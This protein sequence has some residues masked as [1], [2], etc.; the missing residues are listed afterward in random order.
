MGRPPRAV[1]VDRAGSVRDYWRQRIGQHTQDSY[2]GVPMIKF[3]EDLRVYEHLLW[4]S[5][6]D[7]VIEIGCR[8]GGSA[9]W[10][11][12]RLLTNRSYGRIPRAKVISID[13]DISEARRWLSRADPDYERHISL[14]E[15]DV[16]DPATAELAGALIPPGARCLV[17]EDSEHVAETTRGALEHF[18]RFVP[19]G[20]YLVVEDG[21]VDDDELRS[22]WMPSGVLPALSAWLETEPGSAFAVRKDL[23][24]YGVT[25]HPGGF[26]Q[27]T[28]LAGRA[29]LSPAL[30][31]ELAAPPSWMYGWDLGNGVTAPIPG[32]V[33][34]K[35]HETRE[36][37][38]RPAI[39]DYLARTQRTGRGVDLG[40]NEGYY[41]H[42][43]LDMGMEHAVGV[44]VR[45]VNI[46]RAEL[47][48]EHL[49]VPADRL[50]LHTASV[51][52]VGPQQL[53]TFDVVL[54][55][56]LI[57]HLEDPGG[58]LR[59]ARSLAAPGGL[60]V[61]ETQLTAQ[62][63]PIPHGWGVPDHHEQAAA[64]FA[65][66]WE[67]DEADLLASSGGVLSLIPNAAALEAL[68]KAAGFVDTRWL[69]APPG[70]E[71]Q[72][73]AGDRGIV[74]AVAPVD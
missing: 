65:A 1:A 3:P 40:C 69:S 38:I 51:Y 9:L 13:L 41:S 17:I 46:R 6:S 33:L 14:V 63:D 66:R 64:S 2:A 55:L 56:G 71:A 45:S 8:Y 15:G 27:R 59:V 61:V 39:A 62:H 20:G 26:L 48:R 30:R 25:C 68:M 35:V 73:V 18:A 54:V 32:T 31:D 37:M 60:V 50:E 53:G 52:D 36:R 5:R 58:A 10:F 72:F 42:M 47:V 67:D 12:D 34:P 49:G 43:L 4:E 16:T 74:A 24:L 29:D 19:D 28:P 70:G 21:V 57:Y 7:V 22:E 11:R 44:D 23:E